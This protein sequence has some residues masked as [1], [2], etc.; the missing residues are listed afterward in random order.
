MDIVI[1]IPK[2]IDWEDYLREIRT[3]QNGK[4][5]MLFKTPQVPQKANINDRCYLCYNGKIVGYMLICW[6]GYTSSGFKCS[7][8]GNVW[9]AGNYIGRSGRFY[10]MNN[11]IEYKGFRGFRYAP[12]EWRYMKF[13]EME[14]Q[15][16]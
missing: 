10:Q 11:P 9:P 6:I 2:S 15:I 4:D 1:T 8:T 14:I 12:V 7:T 3:A 13:Q 16:N 5:M